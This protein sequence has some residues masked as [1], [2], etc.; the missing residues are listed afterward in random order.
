MPQLSPLQTNGVC[1]HQLESLATLKAQCHAVPPPGWFPALS[2]AIPNWTALPSGA[3]H[4]LSVCPGEAAYLWG[5]LPWD[6]GP[7][8]SFHCVHL[9]S[10][11]AEPHDTQPT[12]PPV[13]PRWLF[14]KCHLSPGR[15]ATSSG[16]ST[17]C[18][19]LRKL[20]LSPIPCFISFVCFFFYF[21]SSPWKDLFSLHNNSGVK[22]IR[23]FVRQILFTFARYLFAKPC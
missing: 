17:T 1:F 5:L 23:H 19:N 14:L 11:V 20:A 8:I 4:F 21:E 7:I 3:S 6:T 12:P 9:D 15:F 10:E 22:I 13:C 18:P 2:R 16:T